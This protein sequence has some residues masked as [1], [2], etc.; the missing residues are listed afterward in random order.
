[1]VT[2]KALAELATWAQAAST[3]RGDEAKL[4]LTKFR[5]LGAAFLS[6]PEFH[7]RCKNLFG[8]TFDHSELDCV[9][10]ILDAIANVEV[11]QVEKYGVAEPTAQ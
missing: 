11:C 3:G 8:R 1:M 7:E 10:Q 2:N 9:C 6:S 4:H 5:H